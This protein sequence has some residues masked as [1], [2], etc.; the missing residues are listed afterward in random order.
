MEDAVH[1]HSEKNGF[2]GSTEPAEKGSS[3]IIQNS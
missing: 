3:M 2:G 1:V